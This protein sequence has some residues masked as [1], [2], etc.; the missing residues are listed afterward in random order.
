MAMFGRIVGTVVGLVIAAFGYGLWK[1]AIF[2]D[3]VDL[4]RIGIGPF[5]PHRTLVCGLI[6]VIGLAVAGAALQR[7]KR[8]AYRAPTTLFSGAD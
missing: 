8:R 4:G 2:A 1:P 5:A 7:Q 3:V 6:I